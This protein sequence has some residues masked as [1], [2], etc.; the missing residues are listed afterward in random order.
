MASKMQVERQTRLNHKRKPPVKKVDIFLWDWD[1]EDSQ[2]L[3][4]TKVTR[5]EGEDILSS[6]SNSQL[7]Y[8]SYSNVWDACEYF[9]E[10]DNDD[11][12]NNGCVVSIPSDAPADNH[13]TLEQAE[14]E[15][16]SK[17]EFVKSTQ[18]CLRNSFKNLFFYILW[19]VIPSL[20]LPRTP[21]TWVTWYFT[22]VLSPLFLCNQSILWILRTGKQILRILVSTLVKTLYQLILLNQL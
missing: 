6:Y 3:V 11:L 9:G 10:S 13:G 15:A 19:I 16:S 8:D 4:Y 5:C 17:N 20:T 7:V 12:S 1:D 21:L 2:Q 14:H 22:M 18:R